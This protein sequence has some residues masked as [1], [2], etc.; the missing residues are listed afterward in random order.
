MIVKCLG[1][2]LGLLGWGVVHAETVPVQLGDT[3]VRVE[4]TMQGQ[5]KAFVHVHQN[6]TTALEAARTV[7]Q[8]EGGSV[9]TLH[10]PGARNI[11][12]HLDHARYEFD[13]NRIF[14]DVGIK[15]TLRQFGAYSPQAH[16][17]VKQLA[18]CIKQ[19][20]PSDQ[21]IIAVHNNK[22]YSIKEYYPGHTLADEARALHVS[23]PKAYRNFYLVTQEKDYMR[24]GQSAFNR[25]LQI[26]SPIDDGSLSVYL[27]TQPYINVEAGYNQLAAQISMLQA[28]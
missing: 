18:N 12:F 20:L 28:I 9:L 19:R 22:H 25:V 24:L 16:Q 27:A 11:V 26:N 21:P 3:T 13:P 2:L 14:S 4:Q 1:L 7:V 5:G 10:H 6:E 23:D 17:Q 15:K 8:A